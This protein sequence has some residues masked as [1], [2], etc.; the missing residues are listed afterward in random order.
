MA[1]AGA[2]T[3]SPTSEATASAMSMAFRVMEILP[4]LSVDQMFRS[5]RATIALRT[6]AA[7]LP[8][9]ERDSPGVGEALAFDC[10]ERAHD[11][12]RNAFVSTLIATDRPRQRPAITS[13]ASAGRIARLLGPKH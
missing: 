9:C 3:T 1:R 12:G 10:I 8:A 11:T 2:V 5:Q 4:T 6:T 13:E 7:H